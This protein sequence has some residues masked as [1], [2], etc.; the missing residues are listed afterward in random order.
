MGTFSLWHWVIA[1]SF[2]IPVFPVST[3]LH[4]AGYSRWWAALYFVPL[5][6]VVFLFI[7]AYSRWPSQTAKADV[8]S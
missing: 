8:F 7:F 6:S 2:L 4:K 1:L 3:I 5:V